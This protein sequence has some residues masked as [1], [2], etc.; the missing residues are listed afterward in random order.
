MS[1]L[2]LEKMTKELAHDFY[3]EFILD[4]DPFLDK[5]KYSPYSYHPDEVDARIT[6][7]RELGRIYLALM[8][9][10]KP[11]G[12]IVLKNIDWNIRTCEFGITLI[13]D[14][15]KNRGFGTAAEKM[16]LEYAFS[17]LQMDVVYADALITNERSCHVLRKAGFTEYRKD[18][19]FVYFRYERPQETPNTDSMS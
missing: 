11:I 19:H 9:D 6:H 12:E 7:Y 8:L 13:N 17:Q 14:T 15:Y 16:I 10:N 18:S 4:P 3:R 2:S 1:I 5:S